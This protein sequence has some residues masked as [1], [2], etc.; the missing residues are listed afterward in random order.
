[1]SIHLQILMIF[2]H[3][4][5]ICHESQTKLLNES[6]KKELEEK[7][8]RDF[9]FDENSDKIILHEGDTTYNCT[10][11][12]HGNAQ[13][14]YSICQECFNKAT[15]TKSGRPSRCKEAKSPQT[16]KHNNC[17]HSLQDLQHD[18]MPHWCDPGRADNNGLFTYNWLRRGKGCVGCN[19]MFVLKSTKG[20]GKLSNEVRALYPALKDGSIAAQIEKEAEEDKA[21][22]NAGRR[23]NLGSE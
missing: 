23:L 3:N 19:K 5:H 7:D 20:I 13:C 11:A 8:W 16:V 6:F 2:R 4:S 10:R 21:K 9:E 15:S 14:C 12:V 17:S 1:M 22:K 18:R